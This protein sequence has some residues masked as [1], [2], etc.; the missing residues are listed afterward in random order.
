M[1]LLLLLLMLY[2]TISTWLQEKI[3]LVD[4]YNIFDY[5]NEEKLLCHVPAHLG[6][7]ACTEKVM[8]SISEFLIHTGSLHRKSF[9]CFPQ[10]KAVNKRALYGVAALFAAVVSANRECM[11][12]SA[13]GP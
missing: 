11:S 12:L 3:V 6:I 2:K 13:V 7:L 5:K 1:L 10:G 9:Y 8:T 4:Y